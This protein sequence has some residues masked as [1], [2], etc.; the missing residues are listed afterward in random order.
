MENVPPLVHLPFSN[1]FELLWWAKWTKNL[2]SPCISG[3]VVGLFLPIWYWCD[4]YLKSSWSCRHAK[5]PLDFVSVSS[6]RCVP[7]W[8]LNRRMN[9]AQS[10]WKWYGPTGAYL[11]PMRQ[12]RISIP[13]WRPSESR[14]QKKTGGKSRSS[15]FQIHLVDGSKRI[16]GRDRVIVSPKPLF[17]GYHIS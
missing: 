8:A 7:N 14:Q 2:N 6:P 13:S 10:P 16:I 17:C 12:P 9:S 15:A 5:S 3:L 4:R 11:Q 1:G